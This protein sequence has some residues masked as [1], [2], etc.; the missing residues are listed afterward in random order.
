MAGEKKS[1]AALFDR[2]LRAPLQDFPAAR[3]AIEAPDNKGV[4]IIYSPDR[5][6]LHVGS[7]PR[8]R[9]GIKQRLRDHMA[10]QSSFTQKYFSR[11]KRRGRQLRDGYTFR[12]LCVPDPRTRALL[13]AL[14]IGRLCPEHIGHGLE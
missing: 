8:A 3:G 6:V 13:E 4:Y 11:H 7:T 5:K 12:C 1:V 9:N 14:A 10:G 2:L